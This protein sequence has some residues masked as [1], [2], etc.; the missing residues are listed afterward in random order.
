METNNLVGVMEIN[1]LVGVMEII[2]W[3]VNELSL[4]SSFTSSP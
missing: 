2:T 3:W 4:Q 1:N